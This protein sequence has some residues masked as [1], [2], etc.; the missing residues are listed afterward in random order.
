MAR[1]PRWFY[2]ALV[3][4]LAVGVGSVSAADPLDA[5]V[6]KA[7]L[8]TNSTIDDG[9]IDKVVGM[10][11]DGSLPVSLVQSTFLWAKKKPENRRFFYF[12]QGLIQRAKE[13]GYNL[14]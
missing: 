13:L 11:N 4:L 6:I 12:K 8:H 14:G 9:F 1:M 10:A 7:V 2:V 5:S 3:V